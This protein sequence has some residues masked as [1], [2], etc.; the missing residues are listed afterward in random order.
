MRGLRHGHGTDTATVSS[1]TGVALERQYFV[2]DRNVEGD[3]V[4]VTHFQGLHWSYEAYLGGEA[5]V[6]LLETPRL[7]NLMCLPESSEPSDS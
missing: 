1:S 3:C 7:D 2:R 6:I 5:G 4:D